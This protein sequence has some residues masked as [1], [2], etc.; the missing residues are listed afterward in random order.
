MDIFRSDNSQITISVLNTD[1]PARFAGVVY[2]GPAR[3]R[4]AMV[5]SAEFVVLAT[6]SSLFLRFGLVDQRSGF[7]AQVD[8]QSLGALGAGDRLV[9]SGTL[10]ADLVEGSSLGLFGQAGAAGLVALV[11]RG[12]TVV[13]I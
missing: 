11:D 8:Q 3:V 2:S 1:S 10:I 4:V 9:L 6:I 12:L 13:V 5:W 7:K